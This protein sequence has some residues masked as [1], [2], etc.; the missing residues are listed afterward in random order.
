MN[1][2][3]V[4][5]LARSYQFIHA[6]PSEFLQFYITFN[7]LFS[8]L[9]Q[10]GIQLCIH[11]MAAHIYN[12]LVKL[13]QR[14]F[15]RLGQLNGDNSLLELHIGVLRIVI[16]QCGFSYGVNVNNMQIYY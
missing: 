16:G 14:I 12:G 9:L 1:A 10:F 5:Q 13:L 3:N 8:E 15:D 2:F 6:S 7:V 4:L 11:F